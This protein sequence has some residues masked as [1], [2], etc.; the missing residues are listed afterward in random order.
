MDGD[1]V[2]IIG[3]STHGTKK[4]FKKL[5]NENYGTELRFPHSKKLSY[6]SN[7]QPWS[8]YKLNSSDFLK[9]LEFREFQF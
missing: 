9:Y 2:T 1:N 5:M 3:I 6:I 7:E 8:I 4:T